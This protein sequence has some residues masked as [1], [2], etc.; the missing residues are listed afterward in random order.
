MAEKRRSIIVIAFGGLRTVKAS[1]AP[2]R[3]AT[4]L[5]DADVNGHHRFLR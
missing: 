2:N 5:I 1:S 4:R 3:S